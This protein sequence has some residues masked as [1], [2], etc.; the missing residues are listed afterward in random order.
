MHLPVDASF[1]LVLAYTNAESAYCECSET[2]GE[3]REATGC[4]GDMTTL[5][6]VVLH[7]GE[8]CIYVCEGIGDVGGN[9]RAQRARRLLTHL[10]RYKAD[11]PIMA[12]RL[13]VELISK[14]IPQPN[15]WRA[16]KDFLQWSLPAQDM[17]SSTK[18]SAKL[19]SA[20]FLR[21]CM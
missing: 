2:Y 3:C 16:M 8:S 6:Q 21:S 13:I 9:P 5:Q 19:A 10:S 7:E 1:N 17:I 20:L 15:G 12:V 4:M 18:S 11:D 14:N